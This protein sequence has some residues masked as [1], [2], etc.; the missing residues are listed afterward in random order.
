MHH[1]ILISLFSLASAVTALPRDLDLQ[2]QTTSGPI[3]G[4]YNDTSSTVRAFLGISYAESPTGNHRFA[5]PQ[6]KSKSPSDS[7][8][9]ASAFTGPCPQAYSHDNQSIWSI[10]PY[11]IFNPAQM[12]EDCLSVN[13]WAPS[14]QRL[15]KEKSGKAA[16][17]VFIHGGAF[18][19]GA[20][21]VGFYDGANLVREQE[22]VI[23]V[24]FNYRLNIFGFPNAPGLELAEQNVGLLDQR[25]AIEWVYNNI[26]NF[27]GDPDRILLFGQSAGAASVD[28]YSYAYPEDPLVSALVLESGTS[29]IIENTDTAHRNWNQL[30]TDLGCGSGAASLSCI[31]EVPFEDIIDAMT[32]GGYSFTP[33]FDN[34]TFFSDYADRAKRGKQAHLPTLGGINAREWS[35]VIPLNQSSINETQMFDTVYNSFSCPLREAVDLRLQQHIPTWRYVYHGNFTNLSPTPWLGAYHT[36]E[37]PILFGTYNLTH[38]Q[39][40]PGANEIAVSKYIQGAWVAFAKDP[41]HG[42]SRYGWPQFRFNG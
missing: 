23:V 14:V 27:G 4:I 35:A 2:I 42:L 22:G 32:E 28:T 21:S 15:R 25:L 12:T 13:V 17:L 36:S 26:A 10:L 20:G 6:P 5:P 8:I 29:A 30:S 16:V 34:R 31:R 1:R 39:P 19:G 9:N 7:P 11:A 24:T 33:V 3:H 37:V 41:Q 38:L 40:R 18:T